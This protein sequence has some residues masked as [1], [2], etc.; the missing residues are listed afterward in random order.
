MPINPYEPPKE[1]NDGRGVA[2]SCAIVKPLERA[3]A[4]TLCMILGALVGDAMYPESTARHFV[5]VEKLEQSIGGALMG[6]FGY[7]VIRGLKLA[8][9]PRT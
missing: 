4:I 1:V 3:I 8:F 5:L 6:A 9:S 7:F 2:V